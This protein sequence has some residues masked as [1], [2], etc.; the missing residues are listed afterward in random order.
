M[1]QPANHITQ[2]LDEAASR[3]PRW[4]ESLAEHIEMLRAQVSAV[5]ELHSRWADVGTVAANVEQALP[6]LQ[7]ACDTI[8]QAMDTLR[9]QDE[10]ISKLQAAVEGLAGTIASVGDKLGSTEARVAALDTKLE[11]LDERLDDQYDRVSAIDST[12]LT[13]AEAMRRLG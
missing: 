10:G 11:R 3:P 1:D 13:L 6:R 9:A 5:A 8:G 2:H 4:A 12:L 7:A